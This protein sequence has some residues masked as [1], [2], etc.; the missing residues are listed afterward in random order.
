[1]ASL[2]KLRKNRDIV[3]LKPKKG[4]GA[5]ILDRNKCQGSYSFELLEFHDFP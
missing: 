3:I 4:K 1:M 2:K 5:I